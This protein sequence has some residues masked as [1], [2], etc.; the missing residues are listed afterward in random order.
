[1]SEM[2]LV[3]KSLAVGMI[4]FC[5]CIQLWAIFRPNRGRWWPFVDYP[6]FSSSY[7]KGDVFKVH[8]L[9]GVPCN[10]PGAS[11]QIHWT[12]IGFHSYSYWRALRE[13][14]NNDPASATRQAELKRAVLAVEGTRVCAL[15]IWERSAVVTRNGCRPENPPW[16][17]VR[18]WRVK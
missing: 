18:E 15:Q 2:L 9:R 4:V 10:E 3:K 8:E 1:M 12:L 6:M 7:Q 5:L 16:K 13:I 17:L 11:Y 14:V